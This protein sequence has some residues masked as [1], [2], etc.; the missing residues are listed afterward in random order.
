MEKITFT[1]PEHPNKE[2]SVFAGK[3]KVNEKLINKTEMQKAKSQ[4]KEKI[5]RK[6]D[7]EL[8]KFNVVKQ[9]FDEL[10]KEYD[11]ISVEEKLYVYVAKS[12]YWKLITD[13]ESQRELRRRVDRKWRGRIN[14]NNLQEIYEWLVLDAEHKDPSIFREGRH[15][16]NFSDVAYNWNKNEAV[17][18][19]KK[20]YLRYALHVPYKAKYNNSGPFN[21]FVRDVF[22][23]DGKTLVEFQK[24][25]G[26]AL[27]DM[28]SLKYAFIFYGPSNGGKSVTMNLLRFLVG[29][30]NTASVSFSQMSSEFH[31]AQ[32][33]NRR[34]NCS[35][36]VSGVTLSRL[37]VFRAL[38]GND[39]VLVSNKLKDPFS[40]INRCLL[41]FSCNCL[42]KISDPLEAQSVVER[43]IIFPFKNV[44]PRHKWDPKLVEHLCEDFP[45]VIDFAIRGLRILEEDDHII[46]ESPA[47]LSCKEYYAGKYDS[48]SL[49][50]KKYIRVDKGNRISSAEIKRTY[51]QF[52]IS[53]DYDEINDSVWAQILKRNFNCTSTTM[54]EKTEE[55]EHRI[56]AYKNITLSKDIA[57]LVDPQAPDNTITDIFYSDD[58]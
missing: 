45:S 47:M 5:Q 9:V 22:G 18:D 16:L 20:L 49:F 23:S 50:C 7:E 52:C 12:G 17:K 58:N 48:F 1:P 42:P 53:N 54:V 33:H 8:E 46:K 55:R 28:R 38:C 29:P 34:I 40:F 44:K 15:Y 21:E 13:S 39:E 11:F 51:H 32:L 30:E 56:R 25:L 41:I 43:L 24:F 57:E 19:R 36:E 27:S 26:L 4:Q 37:D 6:I 2:L 35:A 14:K 10:I 3:S 31:T